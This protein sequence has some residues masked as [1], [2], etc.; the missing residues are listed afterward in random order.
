MFITDYERRKKNFVFMSRKISENGKMLNPSLLSEERLSEIK[1]YQ[2][3]DIFQANYNQ[4]PMDVKGRLYPKFVTYFDNVPEFEEILAVIDTADKGSD[5]LCNIIF[6]VKSNVAYV[7]DVYYTQDPLTITEK[8]VPKRLIY[9][10]V[11]EIQVE[12]NFGGGA[13][14]LNLEK[15]LSTNEH[16]KTIRIHTK[17]TTKNKEARIISNSTNVHAR[18]LMPKNWDKLFPKFYQDVTDYQKAGKNEHDDCAD[19]LTMIIE[20]KGWDYNVYF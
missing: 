12:S 9:H 16:G 3:E 20:A 17:T 14:A 13:Y 15:N 8:E 2:S 18:V 1:Y 5:Y 10:K 19:A 4:E 6:G 11:Q 7:L